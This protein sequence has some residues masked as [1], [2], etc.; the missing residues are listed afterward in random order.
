MHHSSLMS[1]PK[2]KKFK[3]YSEEHV[4]DAETALKCAII[5]A[6]GRI[7]GQRSDSKRD[8]GKIINDTMKEYYKKAIGFDFFQSSDREGKSL[9]PSPIPNVQTEIKITKKTEVQELQ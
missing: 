8:L 5:Q 2:R 7:F 3:S 9:C 1:S 4:L 6:P